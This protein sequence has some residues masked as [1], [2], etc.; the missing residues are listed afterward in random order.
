MS[1]NMNIN[2]INQNCQGIKS[3][4][5]YINS[6][7]EHECNIMF[8]CEHWLKP[9]ELYDVQSTFSR[10]GMWSNLKSSI[11]AEAV[12]QG[13]PYGGT[14]FICKTIQHC[15][16]HDVPQE[17]GRISVIEV[18]NNNRVVITLI[19][20]YLPYFHSESTPLYSETLDKLHG[21]IQNFTSPF[22]LLG[23]MNAQMP[24]TAQLSSQWY[25]SK[26]YNN[27]SMLLYDLVCDYEMT[28]ANFQYKQSVDYTYFKGST[29]TYIDHVFISDQLQDNIVGCVTL[30]YDVENTSDHLPMKTTIKLQTEQTS[31]TNGVDR[32]TKCITSKID[33]N[34][35]DNRQRYTHHVDRHSMSKIPPTDVIMSRE[36]A[37]LQ[38]D[39]TCQQIIRCI[40]MASDCVTKKNSQ[41]KAARTQ[42]PWWTQSTKIAKSRKSF[43]YHI[44]NDCDKPRDGHVYRCYKLSKSRYRQ[45]CRLALNTRVSKLHTT[46]NMLYRTRNSKQ[47]WKVVGNT[48]KDQNDCSKDISIDVLEQHFEQKFSQS[49][50]VATDEIVQAQDSI[51]AKLKQQSKNTEQV[52]SNRVTKLIRQLKLNASPAQDGITAEHLIYALDSQI[53]DHLSYM[54]TLCIQ[55]GVVPENFRRGVLIPIPKKSGCDTTQAK[56]W[57]PITV[58]STFSKLL[59]LYVIEEC[60]GHEFSDLQFGFVK[61]RG[62]EMA[63]ALFH[64]VTSYCTTRGSVVYSCSLDAEGAFDAIPHCVL[65][66]KAQSV[67]PTY[68][69]FVMYEW[70]SDLTINIKWR[71]YYSKNIDVNIGTRQ[72]G[73]S[74]PMLFNIFYQELIDR[75]SSEH[76]G[77]SINKNSYN[78]F[79]Y[80]DDLILTSL[81]I[82]GLQ[83]LINISRNYITSHGLNFNP[84]KTTCTTFGTTHQVVNPTWSLN[85]VKLK[86]DESVTYLGT[87]LSNQTRDHIDSRITAA[88][89]AFYGLQGAGLCVRGAN[90]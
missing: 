88:R 74:S 53:I 45:A 2:I 71:G 58:S 67:L 31:N 62:T 79:C 48:R 36:S 57:R 81:T 68:C 6:L 49:K 86:Q 73:L 24:H 56:N 87:R 54:L 8:V 5:C 60:S 43:W 7:L 34:V 1:V 77:I 76:C 11:P 28:S 52:T 38:V 55:F 59:E 30:P 32:S 19:G 78:V 75:L 40:Q 21:I 14:G 16:F 25:K 20:V 18:L 39:M 29:H 72:G 17:D 22:I 82:T 33:W 47:F 23:D 44:W 35:N 66:D 13:R 61:G 15:T 80:A 3:N 4:I 70:Y 46:L 63:T 85:G 89:R 26:P 42:N 64:D 83:S 65:F 50:R 84:S 9:S 37:Q 90:P 12:L 51:D 10:Q 41:L 69:W 27:H